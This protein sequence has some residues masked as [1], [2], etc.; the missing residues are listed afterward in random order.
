LRG[1][2]ASASL[3][4]LMYACWDEAGRIPSRSS[5]TAELSR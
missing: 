2:I 5:T 3:P 4:N 1:K